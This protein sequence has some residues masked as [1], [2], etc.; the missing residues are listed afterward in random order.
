METKEIN[1]AL[2]K[3]LTFR[4]AETREVPG[5]GGKKEPRSFP[6]ERA[7]KA[8]DVLA[9]RDAGT[10]VVIVAADGQK[11]RVAKAALTKP[12]DP[13]DKSDPPKAGGK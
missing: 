1:P 3:G 10:E 9:V 5:E 6:I 2:L 7:L 4:T 8:S 12:S 11:H 13:S